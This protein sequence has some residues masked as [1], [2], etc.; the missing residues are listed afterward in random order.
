MSRIYYLELEMAQLSYMMPRISIGN[1]LNLPK[2]AVY[3]DTTSSFS[4]TISLI[5]G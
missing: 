4:Y 5:R 2:S 1:M 3:R